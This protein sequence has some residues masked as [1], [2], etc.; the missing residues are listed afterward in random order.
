MKIGKREFDISGRKNYLAAILNITPDSFS[1]GGNYLKEGALRITERLIAEGADIIDVGAQSTR[2]GAVMVSE[3][4]ECERLIPVLRGIK[5]RF[6]IPVS[7]D[8]FKYAVAKAALEEGADM[9]NDECAL[10]TPGMAGLLAGYEVPVVLMHSE[11]LPYG[12]VKAEERTG[13]VTERVRK[14]IEESISIAEEAGIAK[15]RLILDPGVGFHGGT[16][17]DLSLLKHLKE[18]HGMGL[19]LY[20]GVSRKSVIGNSLKIPVDQ[21]DPH[22]ALLSVLAAQAGCSFIR[23]HN[24]AI[25]RQALDLW[26]AVENSL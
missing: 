17:E 9:L 3:E 19:P 4:E 10:K 2:P 16:E 7:V 26:E 8:T 11:N 1:D 15:D 21:R 5:E 23:V 18:L 25:N 13:S 22:T 14:G 6:D 12:A 24:V 20:L